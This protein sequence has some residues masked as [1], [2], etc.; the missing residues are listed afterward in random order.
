MS[1]AALLKISPEIRVMIYEE[2]IYDPTCDPDLLLKF[3]LLT[4]HEISSEAERLICGQDMS[5]SHSL[6]DWRLYIIDGEVE[7]MT[8]FER[9]MISEVHIDTMGWNMQAEDYDDPTE[10]KIE[11]G[12]VFWECYD[13]AIFWLLEIIERFPGLELMELESDPHGYMWSTGL[14]EHLVGEINDT[15]LERNGIGPGWKVVSVGEENKITLHRPASRITYSNPD[16][17]QR[18]RRITLSLVSGY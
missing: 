4:C 5:K 15:E 16:W 3:L 18:E 13:S 8:P 10:A 12:H 11:D 7:K 9:N 17:R 14:G 2:L 6:D 1:T